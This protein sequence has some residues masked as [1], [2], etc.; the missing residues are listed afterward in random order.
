MA[1]TTALLSS[2]Q[3]NSRPFAVRA[4]GKWKHLK[5]THQSRTMSHLEGQV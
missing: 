1:A 2:S 5:A 4:T 3:L